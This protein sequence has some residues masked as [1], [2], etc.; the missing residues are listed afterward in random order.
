MT[1]GKLLKVFLMLLVW[2]ITILIWN[3][4]FEGIDWCWPSRS[5]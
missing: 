4:W 1:F 2:F 5:L 3:N